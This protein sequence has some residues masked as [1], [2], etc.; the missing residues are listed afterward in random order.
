MECR[1]R[2]EI[3]HFSVP[4]PKRAIVPERST[5][6]GSQKVSFSMSINI[7]RQNDQKTT[8]VIFTVLLNKHK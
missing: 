2:P 1:F 5:F 7:S 6:R 8:D 3:V 4:V